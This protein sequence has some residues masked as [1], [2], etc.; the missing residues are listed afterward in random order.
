MFKSSR[1]RH[2][3]TA[4]RAAYFPCRAVDRARGGWLMGADR[5]FAALPKPCSFRPTSRRRR[6]DYHRH[7]HRPEANFYATRRRRLAITPDAAVRQLRWRVLSTLG[8]RFHGPSLW[9]GCGRRRS[10]RFSSRARWRLPR[11]YAD[12]LTA[13]AIGGTTVACFRAKARPVRAPGRRS[14]RARLHAA[15]L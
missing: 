2:F 14:C 9:R 8:A 5:A 15:A 6:A 11:A 12:A 10:G 3:S 13:A 4:R 7:C 1:F